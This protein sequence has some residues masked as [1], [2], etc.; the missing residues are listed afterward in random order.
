M[1][2]LHCVVTKFIMNTLLGR[3]LLDFVFATLPFQFT[4]LIVCKGG[5]AQ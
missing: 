2:S 1:L 4:T 3:Q 5:I